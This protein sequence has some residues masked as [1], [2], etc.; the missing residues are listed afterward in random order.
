[1]VGLPKRLPT[2]ADFRASNPRFSQSYEGAWWAARFIAREYGEDALIRVYREALAEPDR[3]TAVDK[4][5]R[6]QLGISTAPGAI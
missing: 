6:S 1:M 3:R 2:K 5:L 4:A